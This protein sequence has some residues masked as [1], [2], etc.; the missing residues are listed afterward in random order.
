MS[1]GRRHRP[2]TW[3]D[4]LVYP[5]FTCVVLLSMLDLPATTVLVLLYRGRLPPNI[6]VVLLTPPVVLD[7]C[8]AY[9]STTHLLRGGRHGQALLSWL[10]YAP[11]SLLGLS[12]GWQWRAVTLAALTLFHAACQSFVPL[13]L[14][15]RLAPGD[16]S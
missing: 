4:H 12:I 3:L 15:K 9:L 7:L 10:C 2:T 6:V 16:I 5:L 11:L 1:D 13:R 14:A 8:S